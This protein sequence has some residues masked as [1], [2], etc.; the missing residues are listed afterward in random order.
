MTIFIIKS[1]IELKKFMVNNKIK[2]N[3]NRDLPNALRYKDYNFSKTLFN[4]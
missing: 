1:V 4:V 2:N 3:Y